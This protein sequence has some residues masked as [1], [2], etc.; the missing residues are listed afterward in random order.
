MDSLEFV[1][2]FEFEKKTLLEMDCFH[3]IPMLCTIC[4]VYGISIKSMESYPDEK[5]ILY[6]DLSEHDRKVIEEYEKERG[7]FMTRQEYDK[8]KDKIKQYEEKM[9]M[10]ER[11]KEIKETVKG[12]ILSIKYICQKTIIEE[13]DLHDIDEGTIERLKNLLCEFFEKE[14]QEMKKSMEE[15]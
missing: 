6:I 15:T 11:Y 8:Y 5:C 3:F 12:N 7:K 10:I 14:M 4:N 13:V 1:K 9:R 2:Q